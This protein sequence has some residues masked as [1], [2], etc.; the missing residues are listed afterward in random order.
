MTSF[1]IVSAV[2][3]HR[4]GKNWEYILLTPSG[5][6]ITIT[7]WKG[8]LRSIK[9]D[10]IDQHETGSQELSA[11]LGYIGQSYVHDELYNYRVGAT[12]KVN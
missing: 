2:D 1:H 9:A 10:E 11:I 3:L 4:D 5:V 6:T 12:V 7:T 8:C